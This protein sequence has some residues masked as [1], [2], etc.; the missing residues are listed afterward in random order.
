MSAQFEVL[1]PRKFTGTTSPW[2]KFWERFRGQG[3]LLSLVW[4]LKRTLPIQLESFYVCQWDLG[5]RAEDESG[6]PEIRHGRFPDDIDTLE[7]MGVPPS[8][9][10]VAPTSE[11]LFLILEFGGAPAAFMWLE[12]K[13]FRVGLHRYLRLRPPADA[14]CGVAVWVAPSHRGQ[15]L[16]PRLNRQ[17]RLECLDRDS[18]R[19]VS[20][21]DSV[22][23]SSL[24]ADEKV[25]YRRLRH[26]VAIRVFGYAMIYD[27]GRLK[28]GRWSEDDPF[29]LEINT[30]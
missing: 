6:D 4:I 22:Y 8:F 5:R 20:T 12:R 9:L 17:A 21:V 7:K 29:G 24:R 19:L 2:T 11:T 23:R 18:S 27:L 25:G 16:G 1:S 10:P 15:G 3:A 28:V 14:M 30:N 13:G 26:V